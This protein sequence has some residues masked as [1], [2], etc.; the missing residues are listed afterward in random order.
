MQSELLLLVLLMVVVASALV[1]LSLVMAATEGGVSRVTR[2]SLNN[3]ILAVQTDLDLGQFS[4]MKRIEKIHKVQRLIADRYATAGSCAFFRIVC[5]VMDGALVAGIASL[6]GAELWIA[7][8]RRRLETTGY[9]AGVR[10]DHHCG[11]GPD[12]LREGAQPE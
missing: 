11:G 12:T 10:P 3:L 6:F 9:H 1:W 7:T 2:A 8:G 5:N 4:R